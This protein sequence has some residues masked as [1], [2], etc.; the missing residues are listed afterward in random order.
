MFI[1]NGSNFISSAPNVC[2]MQ[3]HRRHIIATA[4]AP[5]RLKIIMKKQQQ[6]QII[7]II[8]IEME[9]NDGIGKRIWYFEQ[10]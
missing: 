4:K 7:T 9:T 2:G 5:C 6:Q 8:I 10:K 1:Y 3:Y